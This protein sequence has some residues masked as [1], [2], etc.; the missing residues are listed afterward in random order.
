[1]AALCSRRT[2]AG[3]LESTSL[4]IKAA[5]TPES[6]KYIK[7]NWLPEIEKWANYARDHSALL[8]QVTTTNPNEAYHRSLKALARITKQTVR[9]KYSLAGII[10]L[11]AQCDQGYKSRAQKA[12]Y[13]WSKKKLSATLGYPWLSEFPYQIQLLLLDEIRAAEE[14]AEKGKSCRLAEDQVTCDCK[15][16]RSYWLPCRHVIYAFCF[17]SIIPEP[18]WSQYASLFDESGFEIYTSREL[19]E[20]E[21]SELSGLSRDL[22]AKLHTSETLDHVRNRFFEL[23]ELTSQ[24]DMEEKERLLKRWEEELASFSSALIGSSLLDWVNKKDHVT[25]F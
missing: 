17:L 7:R 12:A 24:L 1:M 15:F 11:I 25:V 14:L 22:Q 21:E 23:S 5:A 16:A 13:D 3:A 19:V 18:D 20:V 6:A 8:L 2:K 4:A 9:P 10:E